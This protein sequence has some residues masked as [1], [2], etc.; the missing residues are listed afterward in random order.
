MT[1]GWWSFPFC[2]EQRFVFRVNSRCSLVDGETVI[3]CERENSRSFRARR[4]T[5]DDQCLSLVQI[6]L[7]STSCGDPRESRQFVKLTP[8]FAQSSCNKTRTF[9]TCANN[10]CPSNHFSHQVAGS[11]SA[12]MTLCNRSSN[13]NYLTNH[14]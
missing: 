4:G 6:F 14:V 10:K 7:V 12:M 1:S 13:N 5:H 8:N 3:D 11:I 2:F 9:L